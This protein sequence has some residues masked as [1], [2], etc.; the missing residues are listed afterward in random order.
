MDRLERFNVQNVVG[1][2]QRRLFIVKR[3]ETHSGEDK[4]E[5]SVMGRGKEEEAEAGRGEEEAGRETGRGGGK[6]KVRKRSR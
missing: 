5:K 2:I 1:K 4:S 6:K 3:G